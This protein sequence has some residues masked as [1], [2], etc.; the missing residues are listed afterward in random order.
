MGGQAFA[1]HS[2]PLP[3]PRMPP[4]VF[5]L[6]LSQT[7]LVLRQYY[8]QV[9]SPIESPGKPSFG[10]VD[11]L[12]H[13]AMTKEFDPANIEWNIVAE[14]LMYVL[15]AV[16]S[17]Q[18]PGT[19]IVNLAVP[20][21]AEGGEDKYVQIDIHY[22]TSPERFQWEL[23]HSAHGDMWNILGSTIRRFGL[24]V[25]DRGLY[26]RIPEIELLD[27]KKSL[28]FLTESPSEVLEFIGLDESQWWK[29]FEDQ[30]KMFEYAAG[31]RLFW[32]RQIDDEEAE[33]DVVGDLPADGGQ[34]GGAAGRKK[35]KHNDRQRMSKRPIFW[36]WINEFIPR[37]REEGRFTVQKTT[38]EDVRE[39]AFQKFGVQKEYEEKLANWTLL[40]H[41]DEVWREAIK[42]SIP[43]ENI[44]HQFRSLPFQYTNSLDRAAAIRVIKGVVLDGEEFVGDL[45][46]AVKP[47]EKGFYDVE[48]VKLFVEAN[49][50]K[51]ATIG[52]ARQLEK[53]RRMMKEKDEKKKRIAEEEAKKNGE[54]AD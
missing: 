26:L 36:D 30:D 38:R 2:P 17:I 18:Q 49:W 14:N 20:W 21:P 45:P 5:Q 7:H 9:E 8:S 25:N 42:G 34:E 35:L 24:T 19:S 47:N 39:E 23:F 22:L 12:V 41:K 15:G 33:F 4:E 11:F 37:C 3:T 52:M 27:R 51:A 53:A 32:V 40:R 54:A 43:T 1:T 29:R 6:V 31:C 48:A 50:P 46:A 10:D 13:G 28:V 16:A 44:D